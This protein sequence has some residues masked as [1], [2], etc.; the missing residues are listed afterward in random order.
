MAWN[1]NNKKTLL[2]IQKEFI[3]EMSL[4]KGR[5]LRYFGMPSGDIIDFK[6][7][8]EFLGEQIISV[9]FRE[10]Q[11]DLMN[12]NIALLIS[13]ENNDEEMKLF[14]TIPIDCLYG[15]Y[16]SDVNKFM[17]KMNDNLSKFCEENLINIKFQ[18]IYRPL[19]DS[20]MISYIINNYL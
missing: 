8:H 3:K 14:G 2:E 16:K 12:Q 18:H 17:I 6:Y 19:Y 15:P 13:K 11:L 10:D 20:T 7:W 5:K 9:E 4:E 1:T